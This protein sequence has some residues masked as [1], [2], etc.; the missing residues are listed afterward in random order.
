MVKQPEA[1]NVPVEPAPFSLAWLDAQLALAQQQVAQ[2]QA[3]FQQALGV[4]AALSDMRALAEK[5]AE[6]VGT[7]TE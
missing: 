1:G 2:K 4:L 3:E 7:S 6:D 5:E